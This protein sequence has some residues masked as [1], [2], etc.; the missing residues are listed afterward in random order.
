MAPERLG[1]H[2][3]AQQAQHVLFTG[4][5]EVDTH[6][7]RRDGLHGGAFIKEAELR[8]PFGHKLIEGKSDIAGGDRRAVVKTGARVEGDLHP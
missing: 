6:G 2:R 3:Q 4:L 5:A 1:H 8:H 7:Q